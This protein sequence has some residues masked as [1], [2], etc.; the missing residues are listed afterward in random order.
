VTT[1]IVGTTRPERIAQNIAHAGA[2]P[3]LPSEYEAI[4]ARWRAVALADWT[5]QR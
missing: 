1:A 5:G 2:G 3:L 4:R